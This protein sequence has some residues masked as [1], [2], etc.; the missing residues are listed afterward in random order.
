MSTTV[1]SALRPTPIPS[2]SAL[3]GDPVVQAFTLL[4]IGFTVAPILFGIDK[5]RF[6]GA[7]R[8]SN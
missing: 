3:R 7:W 2:A 1:A 8:T 5:R 4:R 6:R